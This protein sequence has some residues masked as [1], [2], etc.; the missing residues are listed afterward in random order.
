[1]SWSRKHDAEPRGANADRLKSGIQ[2][3]GANLH[4][5]H[6]RREAAARKSVSSLAD[7]AQEQDA[8]RSPHGRTAIVS[9]NGRDVGKMRCTGGRG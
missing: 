3:L 1:M 2:E 5:V 9:V 8:A 7:P 6:G 4:G